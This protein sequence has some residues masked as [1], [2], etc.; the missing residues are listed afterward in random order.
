MAYVALIVSLGLAYRLFGVERFD[1][2]LAT[3]F[4]FGVAGAGVLF[5]AFGAR[6][7]PLVF[8]GAFFFLFGL[9]YFL[10]RKLLFVGFFDAL[11]PGLPAVVGFSLLF[12]YYAEPR[13]KTILYVA[14]VLFHTPIFYAVAKGRLTFESLAEGTIETF[15]RLW[16]YFL[17]GFLLLLLIAYNE[18]LREKIEERRRRDKRRGPED[19]GPDRYIDDP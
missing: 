4:F 15:D 10:Y 16:I 6:N 8:L 9:F 13:K 11:L 14:L 3:A 2:G 18:R 7:K 5:F 1:I 17:A 12:V 19:M